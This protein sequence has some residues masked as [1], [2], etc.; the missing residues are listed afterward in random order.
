MTSFPGKEIE[1]AVTV[2]S[3]ISQTQEDKY[4]M[5]F[6]ALNTDICVYVCV[7]KDVQRRRLNRGEKTKTNMS[8]SHMQNLALVI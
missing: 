7:M 6:Y 3:R 5:L 8:F 2:L 4:H 1:P